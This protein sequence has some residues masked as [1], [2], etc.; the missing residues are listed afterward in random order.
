MQQTGLKFE[1]GPKGK[2]MI[3]KGPER[4][5]NKCSIIIESK[6][7]SRKVLTDAKEVAEAFMGPLRDKFAGPRRST[8]TYLT[9]R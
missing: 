5:G 6:P 1:T 9:E 8:T 3:R 7:R 2:V 4:E